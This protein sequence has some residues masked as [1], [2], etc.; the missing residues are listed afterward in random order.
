MGTVLLIL[1]RRTSLHRLGLMVTT[2]EKLARY[3]YAKP[4]KPIHRIEE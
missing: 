3:K 2:T 4:G 1:K